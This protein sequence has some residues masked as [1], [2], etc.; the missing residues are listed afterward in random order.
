MH[1]FANSV[2]VASSQN[3]AALWWRSKCTARRS[4][5][6][7]G[8][9]LDGNGWHPTQHSQFHLRCLS[10]LRPA[11]SLCPRVT[12]IFKAVGRAAG[13]HTS[14]RTGQ[15]AQFDTSGA[16]LL[17]SHLTHHLLEVGPSIQLCAEQDVGCMVV[18]GLGE[19]SRHAFGLAD[20][21]RGWAVHVE[22]R[23]QMSER[24]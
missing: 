21:R 1:V 11:A 17:P 3:I 14:Q 9:S 2:D 6:P 22:H 23:G 8:C 7:R 5:H 18:T 13:E 20:T 19:G 15:E 4:L 10:E 24:D 12:G 16:C